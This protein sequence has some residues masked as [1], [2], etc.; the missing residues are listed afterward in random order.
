MG[1]EITD[2]RFD[3]EAFVEFGRRLDAETRLLHEWLRDGRLD[4]PERRIGF[5]IEGWLVDDAG[6]PVARNREFLAAVDD[7]MVVPELAMFN[8]EINSDALA[9]APGVLGQMHDALLARWRR[10]GAAAATFGIHPLLIGVL[11]TVCSEDL[12]LR[13]MSPLQRYRA[14][15]DQVFR[16]R[17]GKPIR[18]D[19]SGVEHLHHEHEDVMLES[20]TTS[21]QIHVQVDAAEAARAFNACKVLSAVTVGASA[22]SPFLFGK[23]LWQET[24]IPLFEQAVAVGGSDYSKRVTFG[25]RYARHSIIECFEANRLRYPVILPDLMDEPVE[26]LAHLRLHNGTVWRWNR[27]LIGFDAAGRPHCRIEHRVIAAGPTPSDAIA[28]TALFLGLFE[29]LMRASD[30]WQQQV[31][32]E[33]AR[34]NFYAA[35]RHGLEAHLAWPGARTGSLRDLLASGLLDAAA[36]GLHAAGLGLDEAAHWLDPVRARVER[37]MTGADWQV[38]W[39]RRHGRDFPRLVAAYMEKQADDLP[40][41]SWSTN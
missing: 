13:N 2:S 18:L 17:R 12:S 9:L 6:R 23:R 19:I 32:F 39:S 24:R 33:Q 16:L 34:R 20:A 14:I 22:N 30:A 31:S 10:C 40:V 15:N 38:E 35:A 8:F 28:N 1:Q 36:R 29:S 7:P 41:A 3:D 37:R 4:N 27:P 5:E 26:R 21:L 11:P 25:V